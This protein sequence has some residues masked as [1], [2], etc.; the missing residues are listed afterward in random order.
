MPAG[1]PREYS[2]ALRL[3]REELGGEVGSTA[4]MHSVTHKVLS[5]F[6][7]GERVRGGAVK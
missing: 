5:H 7:L 6:E 1:R 3:K 4:C 2:I